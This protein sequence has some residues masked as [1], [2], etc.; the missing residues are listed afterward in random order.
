MAKRVYGDY[1]LGL[2]IGTESVGWAVTDM[3]Y[4]VLKFGSKS[5]W[6]VRLF[7]EAQTAAQRR[8]YRIARR[9]TERRAQRLALLQELFAEE[10]NRIDPDFFMRL[11]EG[12]LHMEDRTKPQPNTL[13]NDP[14]FN[15]KHYHKKYPTIYH[16][17][18]SLITSDEPHDVRL[19][20]LAIH[21]IIKNRGHFLFGGKLDEVPTLEEIIK[22]MSDE[23]FDAFGFS[24]DTD[25]LPELKVVLTD[26]TLRMSDKQKKLIELFDTKDG[27]AKAFIKAM[28]GGSVNLHDLFDLPAQE[29]QEKIKI[30]FGTEDYETKVPELE[31]ILGDNFYYLDKLKAIHDW[32]LLEKIVSGGRSLSAAKAAAYEEHAAD[33]KVL[34]RIVKHYLPA[35]YRRIFHSTDEKSNYAAYIGMTKKNGRKIPIDKRCSQ[36]DFMKFAASILSGIKA[37]DTDIQYLQARIDSKQFM[38][39]AITKANGVIPNQLHFVELREILKNAQRYLPFLTIKDQEGLTISD[40]IMQILTFRIPY[41]VGPLNNRDPRAQ[42]TW[43][44]RR[45]QEKIYP[46]NFDRVVDKEASAAEFITRMTGECTYLRGEKVLPKNS[47][48]YSRFMVLN[49]LNNLKI[50]GEPV[51]LQLKQDIYHALFEQRSKVTQKSLLD[52]LK[53]RGLPVLSDSISGIDGDFKG[54]MKPLLEMQKLLGDRYTEEM[55]EEI[56]RLST[57]FGDDKEML[58]ARIKTAYGGALSDDIIKRAASKR[59]SGWGNLSGA[60]L[61]RMTAVNPQTGEYQSMMTMLWETNNNLMQLL[62]RDY[63][64]A[65]AVENWQSDAGDEQGFSYNLVKELYVSPSV[66]RAVWQALQIVEEIRKITGKDPKKL[67]IEVARGAEKKERKESR[68]KKL[69]DLYKACGEDARELAASLEQKDESDF[70]RDRLY[71]YYTQMGRCMYTGNPI[72]LRDIFNEQLYDIDHIY[73]QS[74]VKD[75]SLDNRVLVER[76]A[77]AIKGDVYPLVDSIRAQNRGYWKMLLDRGFISKKKYERLARAT[78][79]EP[80]ELLDFIARQLVE[81]RQSTKAVAGILAKLLPEARMVYVKAGLVSEFRQKFDLLKCREI[82]DLHH[83]ADAYLNIV[84]GNAYHTKFTDD[85]KRFF[86][87]PDHHYNLKEFYNSNITRNGQLAWAAGDGGTIITVKRTMRHNNA[88]VTRMAYEQHGQLSNVQLV[89]KNLW[90]LPQS[91]KKDCF[92]DPSKY[93]GY[94]NVSGSYFMLVEHDEKKGVRC[95]SLIDMPLHLKD[96]LRTEADMAKMLCTE[97]GLSNPRVI[98]PKINLNSLLVIDGFHMNIKGRTG[99]RIVYSPSIQI[100][101]GYEW[102][103]YYRNVLKF[104][105]RASEHKKNS[106]ESV[107]QATEFDNIS[108]EQNTIFYDLLVDKLNRGIYS[109]MFKGQGDNLLKARQKYIN[110]SIADQCAVLKEVLNLFACNRSMANFTLIDLAGQS[111]MLTTNRVLSKYK[112][113]LLIHQSI[114]GLFEHAQDLLA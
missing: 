101:V 39:K 92:L 83:A 14:G 54:S 48:L 103:K 72:V 86:A 52:Y 97:K 75:D 100:I 47:I 4:N 5:M 36:D 33:L 85:P 77:N 13:F 1:Y 74:K 81:T 23:S 38:P 73:P 89:K 18:N 67:F 59:F 88:L 55:A 50:N 68:K 69:A 84:A 105:D 20:Y 51:T 25:H 16:L 42:N 19:V 109:I 22:D 94:K 82:N 93:G 49:E 98:I 62:S 106:K 46:W 107:L 2:D 56:I 61:T 91:G 63:G 15:D 32:A 12:S 17:R 45:T 27:R 71:L 28:T 80:N 108:I 76:G 8:L 66:K 79:L 43:V 60:F 70:R 21:H 31:E 90:Q 44:V 58:S 7:P 64:F 10:I 96:A 37:D 102:E 114:T 87:Q 111:G 53:S 78:P 34:K 110:L 29:Q 57:I 6:G 95:R 24:L 65:K 3:D 41:Y 40:K 112:T 30:E 26:K 104:V 99:Q 113:A 11:G 35:E 9:R